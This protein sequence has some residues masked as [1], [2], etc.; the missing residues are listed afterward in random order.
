MPGLPRTSICSSL[1]CLESS[2]ARS[3]VH[4]SDS[5]TEYGGLEGFMMRVSLGNCP[6]ELFTMYWMSKDVKS[7]PRILE[8]EDDGLVVPYFDD[9]LVR[10]NFLH[11][12]V[13]ERIQ[14]RLVRE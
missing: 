4:V 2:V 5:A 3:A 13:G 8:F 11:L 1:H 9:V 6:G 10:R 12:C 14:W 7:V